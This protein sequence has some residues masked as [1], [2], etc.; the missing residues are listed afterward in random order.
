MPKKEFKVESGIPIT[1]IRKPVI[2]PF[3]KMGVN[4][5]FLI[6]ATAAQIKKIR[7]SINGCLRSYNKG[8]KEKV[9][10]TTRMVHDGIRVWII[11]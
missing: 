7:P 8:V 9:K 11:K 10:I 6:P 2:Y 1:R 3:D 4:D 5:S